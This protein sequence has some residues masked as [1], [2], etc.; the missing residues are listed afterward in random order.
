[1]DRVGADG[2]VSSEENHIN[3]EDI[4]DWPKGE[5]NGYVFKPT[6]TPW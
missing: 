6:S 1:M 4:V 2:L 3:K 5:R